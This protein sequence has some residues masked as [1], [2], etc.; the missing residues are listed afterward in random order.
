[1]QEIEILMDAKKQ[2]S[3]TI[4]SNIQNRAN[5]GDIENETYSAGYSCM[6]ILVEQWPYWISYLQ[7]CC[8]TMQNQINQSQTHFFLSVKNSECKKKL[9]MYPTG[10]MFFLVLCEFVFPKY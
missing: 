2:P 8:L 5:E 9:P 3:W 4:L 10:P 7:V 1:M 6:Q